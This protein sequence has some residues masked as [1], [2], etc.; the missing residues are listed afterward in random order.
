MPVIVGTCGWQYRHWIGCLY[1][2]GL[3][4][5]DWLAHYAARFAAVEIDSAFY[6]LPSTHTF[7]QWAE[8]TPPDFT[9]A[10]KA[11]RYL[12]HMR[13]L[14]DP[15]EAVSRLMEGVSHLGAKMGPVL[16]QL[17][18]DFVVNVAALDETLAAFPTGTKVAFEPRHPSW[19]VDATART[20]ADHGAA[21]CLTDTPDRRCPLWRTTSWGY[22]RFHHGRALPKSCYGRGALR[23]WAGR[24]AELW[25]DGND[26]YAFFNNDAFGCAVR[27]AHAFAL[28][29]RRAGLEVTR[30]ASA[31]E[32]G[33]C[34]HETAGTTDR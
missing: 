1:P 7:E 26:V 11:S 9:M 27:D 19:Y 5:R 20:L 30:V 17:P 2:T 22:L 24:L 3:P 13:R 33:A 28:A 10:V 14:R 34:G 8:L 6:H 23:T 16:L 18:Q 25:P 32:A 15:G 4:R 31:A 12:T 21:L 29:L